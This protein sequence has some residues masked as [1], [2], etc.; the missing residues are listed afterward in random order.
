MQIEGSI[1]NN[2]ENPDYSI[3]NAYTVE[4]NWY[5]ILIDEVQL[6]TTSKIIQRSNT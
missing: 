2:R 1:A 6:Q 4:E 5:I 3:M